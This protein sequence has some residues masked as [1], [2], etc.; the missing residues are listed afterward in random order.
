MT[1]LCALLIHVIV[2]CADERPDL[3][4]L[5]RFPHPAQDIKIMQ[6]VIPQYK[7]LGNILLQ[8]SN[9]VRVL[10]IEKSKSHDANDVVYEIFRQWLEEDTDATWSKLVQCLED[11]N[12]RPLAQ[13]INSCLM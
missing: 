2:H 12:L 1:F 9:G 6:E 3:P 8:S 10:G 13:N 11:V 4:T 5:E 7:Q